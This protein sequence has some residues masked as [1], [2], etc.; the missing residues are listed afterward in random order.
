MKTVSSKYWKNGIRVGPKISKSDDDTK[1]IQCY[2]A[3][4]WKRGTQHLKRQK[5]WEFHLR[6]LPCMQ[7]ASACSIASLNTSRIFSCV[8]A[9]QNSEATACISLAIAFAL[10]AEIG[11]HLYWL[12]ISSTHWGS[13]LRSFFNPNS[14]SGAGSS[15]LLRMHEV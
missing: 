8:I 12:F 1:L 4:S 15:L 14:I 10:L 2:V 5:C 7:Y 11:P 9:E 3:N 13:Y 6:L